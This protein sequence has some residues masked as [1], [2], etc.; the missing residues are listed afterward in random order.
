VS[1]RVLVTP[2]AL[3]MIKRIIDR[4]VRRQVSEA[5]SC[6]SENPEIKGKSLMGEMA[7]YRA[8]RAVGKKYRVIYRIEKEKVVV[9][10]IAVGRRKEGDRKDIYELAKRLFEQRLL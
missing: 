7:G 8:M 5:I 3:N 9:I 10:V 4:R 1:W 2:A 6:L